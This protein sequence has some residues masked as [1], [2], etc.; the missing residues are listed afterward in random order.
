MQ[1]SVTAALHRAFFED[2]AETG[3]VSL[4][5][6]RIAVR[7]GIGGSLSKKKPPLKCGL[8]L[9]SERI[10][11]L[12]CCEATPMVELSVKYYYR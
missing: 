8:A 5:M 11:R 10:G 2:W 1:T 9:Y 7:A 4:R 6:E 3:Y 12:I